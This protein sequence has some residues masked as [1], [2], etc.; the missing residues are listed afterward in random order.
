M[1]SLGDE[2][3]IVRFK[4]RFSIRRFQAAMKGLTVKQ[5]EFLTLH[6]FDRLLK[7]KYIGLFPLP[8]ID[9]IMVNMVP[10]EGLFQHGSKRIKFKKYMVEQFIGIQSGTFFV[11]LVFIMFFLVM[12]SHSFNLL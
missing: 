12:L 7:L 11:S 4:M 1:A 9:W 8:L 5:R 3:P 10:S 2:E 6:G